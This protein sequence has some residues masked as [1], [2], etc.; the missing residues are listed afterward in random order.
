MSRRSKFAIFDGK[1]TKKRVK[2]KRK[3]RFSFHFRVNCLTG[4]F[5]PEDKDK[6]TD[7]MMTKIARE[8]M[9]LCDMAGA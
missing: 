9:E 4:S 7:E 1:V 3:V 8:Y 6:L 5:K 2:R